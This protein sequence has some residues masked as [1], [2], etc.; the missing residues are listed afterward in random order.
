MI[1]SSSSC[2][3]FRPYDDHQHH[4]YD[5]IHHVIDDHVLTCVSHEQA[6]ALTGRSG[7]SRCQE[8]QSRSEEE[9]CEGDDDDGDGDDGDD[10]DHGGWNLP[11]IRGIIDPG[12]TMG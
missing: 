12:A 8:L 7:S 10:G 9:D 4:Q 6:W 5:H 2:S 1:I 11:S 3:S